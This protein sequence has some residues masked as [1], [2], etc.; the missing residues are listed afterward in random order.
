MTSNSAA[1][2]KAE[3]T[4]PFEVDI[5]PFPSPGENQLVLRNHVVAINP[6]DGVLQKLAILPFKCPTIL[7]HDVAGVVESVGPNVTRFKKGDRLLGHAAGFSSNSDA[8]KGFQKFTL[9]Q[10]NLVCEIPDSIS[11]ERAAV[12]PVG[13]STAASAMFQK[14]FLNMQF[15]T[16]PRRKPTG[17]AVLIWGGSS[18]VGSN[19]IMLAVA[20]GYEV[21]TTASPTN[22][23]Y[24]KKLG[25]SQVF[26]YNKPTVIGDLVNAFKGKTV[27]GALDCIAGLA[28][29]S[30]FEVLLNSAGFRFV[31]T[32]IPGWPEPPPGVQIKHIHGVS[33][34]D[35]EVSKAIYEDF[36]PKALQ[37]GTFIPAPEPFIAGQ[38]LESI[39][40]AVYL[41]AKGTSAKKVV[42][43][44]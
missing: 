6:I 27:A 33:L 42:V 7:G 9:L 19:G 10:T 12:I 31:A 20:A 40:E 22:F 39:Q 11:F 3:K 30:H 29:A 8:E 34:K 26:D 21:I 17:E 5:A 15:P 36:L 44:L 13:C 38:G 43:L 37:L 18:S 4:E 25:A 35:N 23:E 16:E 41:Q 32:T 24:V 14:D 2:L 1:W 28:S